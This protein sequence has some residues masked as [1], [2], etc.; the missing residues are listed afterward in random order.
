MNRKEKKMKPLLLVLF[1]RCWNL[2]VCI[3]SFYFSLSDSLTSSCVLGL[4]SVAVFVS[5]HL[6]LNKILFANC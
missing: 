2:G 5:E 6:E 4:I 1:Y 3:Y